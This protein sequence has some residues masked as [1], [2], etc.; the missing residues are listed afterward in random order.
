M[1][2]MTRWQCAAYRMAAANDDDS[3]GNG[4]AMVLKL[5]GRTLGHFRSANFVHIQCQRI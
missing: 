3:G 5:T 1:E 4:V 2:G